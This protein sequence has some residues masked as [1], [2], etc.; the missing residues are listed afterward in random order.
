[1]TCRSRTTL[2]LCCP[3]SHSTQC[4]TQLDIELRQ[5]EHVLHE[6]TTFCQMRVTNWFCIPRPWWHTNL[7]STKFWSGV[8][9]SISLQSICSLNVDWPYAN[10]CINHLYMSLI[11]TRYEPADCRS[12]NWSCDHDGVSHT[13]NSSHRNSEHYLLSI[14]WVQRCGV[15]L[16]PHKNQLGLLHASRGVL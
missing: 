9:C 15:P 16:H 13:Q 12:V 10:P 2:L 4:L 3:H 6:K 7:N 8:F 11:N 5:C 1:M 14:T